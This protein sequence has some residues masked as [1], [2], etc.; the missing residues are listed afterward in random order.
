MTELLG[1]AIPGIPFGCVFA[2]MAIGLVLTYTTSG[3][4]NLAFGAQ[5]FVSGLAFVSLISDGWPRWAAALLAI[6]VLGPAV[7]LAL[8]R[9]L[10]R[11]VRTASPIVKLVPSLGLLIALPQLALI[12][13]GSVPT[14]APPA[15]FLDAQRVYA[16]VLGVPVSGLELSIM[17]ATAAVVALL[18]VLARATP[19][20]LQMRAVVESPRLVELSGINAGRVGAT[21]WVISS[22]F[23]GLA[24]VLLAPLYSQIDPQNYTVLLVWG[25]AAAVIARFESI[26]LAL[27]G[28]LALGIGQQV[29]AGYLPPGVIASG[30]RPS[31]P[32][33]VLLVFLPFGRRNRIEDPLAGCDP[34][35]S[36]MVEDARR[37][38]PASA[39]AVGA[40][41]GTRAVG[42]WH[43]ALGAGPSESL[44]ARAVRRPTTVV[45]WTL[46]A[47]AVL[48]ALTWVPADWLLTMTQGLAFG[49]VFVSL[50]LLTGMSGQIS[51][52]QA[53]FAGLG[54]FVAGQLATQMGWPVLVAGVAGGALAALLGVIVA[55]PTLRLAGLPLALAT[56]AFALL[57]D[58]VLFPVSWLGDGA[59]GVRLPRPSIGPVRFA[60]ARPFF[61]LALVLLVVSAGVVKRIGDGTTGRYLFAMRGSETA[62]SSVG[63]DVRKLRIGVFAI[64]AGIA[65]VGGALYGSLQGSL[66]PEDFNYEISLVLLV[67]AAIVGLGSIGGAVVAGLVYTTLQRA[68]ATLPT[69]Y[70]GLVAVL[71]GLATL[72]YTRHPEGIV[73]FLAGRFS[74]LWARLLGALRTPGYGRDAP[75]PEPEAEPAHGVA[76]P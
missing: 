45:A 69:R 67:V 62:A 73:D 4:F 65:G 71:F 25:I 63:I 17:V 22:C 20:G 21:A 3:V 70:A 41:V 19:L 74:E 36:T 42:L 66:V 28:G 9:L 5:A 50:T 24:G 8:D 7:G 48:S 57:A 43:R 56:L 12:I 39:L 49:T 58:N 46:A 44:A 47:L 23:A 1:Y 2:L 29:L 13:A 27:G 31:L 11:R 60:A 18:L 30:L 26:P 40:D 15:L 6:V 32:F 55:L 38:R 72:S 37:Y 54:G 52:C 33:I 10:F 51:L 76:R 14:I 61:I 68:V 34:P 64:S 16:H 35:P 75:A 59:S 53:S